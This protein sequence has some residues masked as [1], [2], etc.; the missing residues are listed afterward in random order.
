MFNKFKKLSNNNKVYIKT[1]NSITYIYTYIGNTVS[2]YIDNNISCER[3]LE[4][5][6][7]TNFSNIK[8]ALNSKDI[9]NDDAPFVFDFDTESPKTSMSPSNFVKAISEFTKFYNTEDYRTELTGLHI[10]KGNIFA[11]DSVLMR[12]KKSKTFPEDANMIID[13]NPLLDYLDI[14][15]R[16]IK[17]KGKALFSSKKVST[18]NII[19][20]TVTKDGNDALKVEYDN[21]TFITISI[22]KSILSFDFIKSINPTHK[23]SLHRETLIKKLTELV[24]NP[25]DNS[26]AKKGF[27]R[28]VFGEKL[29]LSNFIYYIK[30]ERTL[31]ISYKKSGDSSD[32]EF[33]LDANKLLIILKIL[34]DSQIQIGYDVNG[35]ISRI[36][37]ETS[38][39]NKE[40]LLLAQTTYK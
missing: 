28:F 8:D 18:D 38:I 17:S 20:S 26:D 13:V 2:Y 39:Q 27:V 11:S 36:T 21:L 40:L 25:S 9:I 12:L 32:L 7:L 30:G 34:K 5:S 33:V 19:L 15:T 14:N 1:E 6:S 31:E 3:P 10:R 23:I 37:S 16:K 29:E 35:N 24:N 4:I 22:G